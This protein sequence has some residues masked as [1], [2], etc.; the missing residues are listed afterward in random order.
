MPW[1]TAAVPAE[2]LTPL[3]CGEASSSDP[4]SGSPGARSRT[5]VVGLP[6]VLSGRTWTVRNPSKEHDMIKGVWKKP[7][8][9]E[10]N[11][12][13]CVEVQLTPDGSIWVRNS[14]QGATGVVLSFDKDEWEAHLA[15]VRAGEYDLPKE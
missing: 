15:A 7:G 5:E 4:R 11:G 13:N 6:R 3:G 10:G 9:C 2:T 14:K 12:G 1:G 8:K